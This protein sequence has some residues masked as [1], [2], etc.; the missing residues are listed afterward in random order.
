MSRTIRR[1]SG[2]SSAEVAALLQ[3]V[4]A[5]EFLRPSKTIWLVSPWISDVEV[6]DN[7]SS[8]FDA[9]GQWGPRYVRLSE[10]LAA[11]TVHGTTVVIA[12]TTA[13]TNE[14]FLENIERRVE[15]FG[16]SEFLEI[17]IESDALHEKAL[18]TDTSLIFGSMNFTYNGIFIRDE[19]VEFTTDPERVSDARL[20]NHER[21]GGVL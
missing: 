21:F 3:S 4:F 11:L 1:S 7:T 13:T 10:I 6:I 17:A 2:Q 16:T 12:T 20:D 19:L 14:S 5:A 8:D 18:T 15:S 9:V